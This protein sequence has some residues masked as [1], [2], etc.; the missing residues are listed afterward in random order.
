[1]LTHRV[2][3]LCIRSSTYIWSNGWLLPTCGFVRRRCC[4]THDTLRWCSVWTN[5]FTVY[6][7]PCG[8][9]QRALRWYSVWAC[10]FVFY[11]LPRGKS[12]QVLNDHLAVERLVVR[13]GSGY[14]TRLARQ[15]NNIRLQR[16]N[17]SAYRP[18]AE[19]TLAIWHR[20]D[21]LFLPSPQSPRP[22]RVPLQYIL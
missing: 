1:M 11:C 21:Q 3:M 13:L 16:S 2:V 4:C 7:L 18:F 15:A 9:S 22:Q 20:C 14:I 12:V 17:R 19:S 5:Y 8:K 10:S 6:W